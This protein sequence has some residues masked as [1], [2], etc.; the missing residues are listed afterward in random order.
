MDL[1]LAV[2]LSTGQD[3]ELSLAE[4]AMSL[5]RMVLPTW[6]K[7]IGYTRDHIADMHTDGGASG[8]IHDG[9]VSLLVSDLAPNWLMRCGLESQAGRECMKTRSIGRI[10]RVVII[11]FPS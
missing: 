11:E 5:M 9:L 7:S 8:Y 1:S 10:L 4:L 2:A 6:G 3:W